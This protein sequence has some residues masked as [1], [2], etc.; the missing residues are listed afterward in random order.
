MGSLVGYR[1]IITALVAIVAAIG[2]YLV[3][4]ADLQATLTKVWEVAV[5]I[6]MIFLRLSQPTAVPATTPPTQ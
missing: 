5:P 6:A 2:S 3:G 4:D 1:T